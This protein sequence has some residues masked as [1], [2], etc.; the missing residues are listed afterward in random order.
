[1]Q[2]ESE[3]RGTASIRIRN[4]VIENVPVVRRSDGEY[5]VPF[6]LSDLRMQTRREHREA[7]QRD[8]YPDQPEF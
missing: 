5:D 7:L 1:M 4:L 8:W 6:K 2:Q 3:I